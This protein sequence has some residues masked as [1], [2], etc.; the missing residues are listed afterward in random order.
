MNKKT[1]KKGLINIK[2]NDNKCFL[3]C[4]VR[5]EK[6]QPGRIRKED[7]KLASNLNYEGIEFP[8]LKNDYCRVEK[9]NNICISVFCYENG[10][11]Y[12]IYV[13]GE[14]FN[15]CMDLLLIF[16]ENK[17]HYVYIKYFTRFMFSKTKNKNKKYFCKCCLQCF[18]SEKVLTEH[19]ENCLVINYKKNVKLGKGSIRFKNY[20]KQL[21]APF[22]IY[23]Y[24]VCILSA[25]P[26]R[27]KSSDK[28]NGSYTEKYQDHFPC[29]FAYKVVCVDNKFSKDVVLYREKILKEYEYCRKVIKNTL[30]KIL[31]CLQK[32]KKK[33]KKKF[34]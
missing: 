26:K 19:K 4:H 29:S 18:S 7:K 3:W 11:N 25:T 13:S 27:V 14:K 9:Q 31:L 24:F 10:L 8:I 16:D 1:K 30:T 5:H 34:S 15:D 20:S 17:S 22:K 6:K 12:P 2:N 33:K 32:K 23:A 28:N 21:P